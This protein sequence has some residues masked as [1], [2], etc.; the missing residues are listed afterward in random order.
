MHY[1]DIGRKIKT[2]QKILRR[3][4]LSENKAHLLLVDDDERILSLLSAYLSK[5]D[6]LISSANN[7]TEARCLLDYFAFDLLVIDIMMPGESGLELLE[8]IR[9][10]TNVPAIFLSAKG[11]SKDKISGL[12]IGADDYLSKPFEPKELLLRLERLLIR[13]NKEYSNKTVKRIEFG[14]KVFDLQRLELYQEN[15]LIKLTNLEISL[16][17][18][19]ALNPAKIIS[20][21][22]VISH[23]E[24]SQETRNCNKRNVD[25]QITRLRKK[26]E[27]DPANP[28]HLKTIRGKGY[29]FLP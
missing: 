24:I 21:Q 23:L 25:V 29:L 3:T 17:N 16:L 11:E 10:Q 18:F 13:N 7:S 27:P 9:K 22:R 1:S 19:F 8:N 28:R 12:E 20:R 5:N 2:L 14:N 4:I 6:F 15:H 26:I